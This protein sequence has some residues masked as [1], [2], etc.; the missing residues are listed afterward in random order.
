MPGIGH[1]PTPGSTGPPLD[2]DHSFGA[3]LAG[4]YVVCDAGSAL[5]ERYGL[6]RPPM[7]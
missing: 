2:G 1:L 6:A 3:S 7:V 4:G 5:K